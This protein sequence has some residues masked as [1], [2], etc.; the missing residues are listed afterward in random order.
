MTDKLTITSADGTKH[1]FNEMGIKSLRR[2]CKESPELLKGASVEDIVVG[3]GAAAFMIYGGIK[4]VHAGV[5]S[6]GAKE[7]F[8]AANVE[9]SCDTEVEKIIAR[10]NCKQCGIE[11]LLVDTMSVNDCVK[12]ISNHFND[13]W[14]L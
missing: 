9:V 1:P 10:D 8:L 4:K 7:M 5:L 2:I 14:S 3:K 13:Q 11:A 6:K 12:R